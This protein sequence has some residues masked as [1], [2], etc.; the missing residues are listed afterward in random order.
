MISQ[1]LSALRPA[2]PRVSVITIT[3]IPDSGIK[4]IWG[5]CQ[6][7]VC[8]SSPTVDPRGPT[9]QK[10]FRAPRRLFKAVG[11][12]Q[13]PPVRHQLDRR[14][15]FRFAL[16]PRSVQS[17]GGRAVGQSS[18]ARSGSLTHGSVVASKASNCLLSQL[19]QSRSSLA[20]LRF[21]QQ[22]DG[23]VRSGLNNLADFEPVARAHPHSGDCID[24][25]PLHI[26]AARSP[27]STNPGHC[28]EPR[29]ENTASEK[30]G[31]RNH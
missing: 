15:A 13:G 24:P 18:S 17:S 9:S 31:V 25:A 30:K 1:A 4:H 7:A 19:P 26:R 8:L 6:R 14:A 12:T 2:T 16:K 27:P 5:I 22:L 21:G 28:R 11:W 3:A 20:C 29:S 23:T 10:L